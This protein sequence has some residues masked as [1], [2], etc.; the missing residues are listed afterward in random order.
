MIIIVIIIIVIITITVVWQ[1]DFRPVYA[2]IWWLKGVT[3]LG[4]DMIMIDTCWQLVS[5]HSEQG[6]ERD[7]GKA[8][9]NQRS[10]CNTVLTLR[11]LRSAS[12]WVLLPTY[13]DIYFVIY[14]L[15][16][17]HVTSYYAGGRSADADMQ[18]I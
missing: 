10:P 16:L 4:P 17:F 8:I 12:R 9:L 18:H 13:N 3:T 5:W 14:Y 15:T 7:Q 1:S 2:S 11:A 6:F